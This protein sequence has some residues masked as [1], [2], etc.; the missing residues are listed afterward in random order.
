MMFSRAKLFVELAGLTGVS[1]FFAV[2]NLV[3]QV[4]PSEADMTLCIN[5]DGMVEQQHADKTLCI[6]DDGMLEQVGP[7][8][9]DTTLCINDD[10]TVE[11]V[12]PAM[13]E[14]DDY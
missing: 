5:D 2:L 6:N 11:Q 14:D 4:G 10:G 1:L 7:S 12:G 13:Q 8:E 9:A 3:E